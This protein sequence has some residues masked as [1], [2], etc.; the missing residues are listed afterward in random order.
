MKSILLR[1]VLF[2]VFTGPALAVQ[3]I[4]QPFSEL[5][6]ND[7]RVLK[8]ARLKAF[9]SN[10]VFV[11][12]DDG[13]VQVPYKLFPGELQPQLAKARAAEDAPS[14]ATP[15]P[16]ITDSPAPASPIERGSPPFPYQP[17]GVSYGDFVETV[18]FYDRCREVLGPESWVR[19]LRWDSNRMA[20]TVFE[21]RQHLWVWSVRFGYRP[22][23]VPL[24][25][26][27]DI[28]RV[29]K[30]AWVGNQ[31]PAPQGPHYWSEPPQQPETNLPTVQD[32][33]DDLVVRDATIAGARLGAHRPVN[34]VQFSYGGGAQQGAAVVFIF[35]GQ[36]FIYF[37]DRGTSHVVGSGPRAILN[38]RALQ[39]EINQ[40]FPGTSSLK[41]LNYPQSAP[42][43]ADGQN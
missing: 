30:A 27:E 12:D 36:I 28:E 39:Y 1:V 43:S 25:A 10:T 11:R 29:S 37:P 42:V 9:N 23:D 20:V 41:S 19:I 18:C 6:L 8:N 24:E 26:R 22:L 33:N 3:S 35:D 7:G 34:V 21:Q 5:K 15:A 16:R 17:L 40:L 38:L 31:A 13:F 32:T 4:N 14:G 2:C